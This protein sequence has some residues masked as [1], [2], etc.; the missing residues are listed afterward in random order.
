MTQA[1][2]SCNN[3]QYFTFE[4]NIICF[5]VVINLS[6][7]MFDHIRCG[8]QETVYCRDHYSRETTEKSQVGG[9]I[10][11]KPIFLCKERKGSNIQHRWCTPKA[12]S[13]AVLQMLSDLNCLN[14]EC[15][16]LLNG[17]KC[18]CITKLLINEYMK[19]K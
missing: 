6:G 9:K 15:S 5:P 11:L 14:N 4:G 18:C 17:I 8:R 1:Y 16:L 19:C 10:D 7:W 2:I 13:P 3:C 12:M